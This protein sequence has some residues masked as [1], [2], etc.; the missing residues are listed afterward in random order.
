MKKIIS[1][2]LLMTIFSFSSYS[3]T[4]AE[5]T[6]QAND[7][8]KKADKELNRVYG[9]LVK[10]LDANEKQAL[11]ASEKAWIQFRDLECK[12][13][14]MDEEGG[15]IHGM[16]YAACLTQLT[17]KHIEELKSLLSDQSNH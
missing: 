11:A 1:L 2:L 6:V 16:M 14:C 13:E 10:K 12:F 5:L 7:Q 8:Y 17:E 3:Q 9:L 4:Q 15:S